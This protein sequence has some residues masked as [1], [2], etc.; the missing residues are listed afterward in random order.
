MEGN[1]KWQLLLQESCTESQPQLSPDEKWMAYV[2]NESGRTEI[3][4]RSFPETD[5]VREQIP[6]N[7]GNNPLWSRDGRELYY[8]DG[9][10]VM[11]VAIETNPRLRA[12][13]PRI[14]FTEGTSAG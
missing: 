12:E 2:S 9:S 14:L 5:K 4:V 11:A 10:N 3:Y 1:P 8:R 13:K 7:G 6:T